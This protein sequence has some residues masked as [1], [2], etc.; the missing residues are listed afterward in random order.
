MSK[1]Q[2]VKLSD[3]S[4]S[5]LGKMLDQNKN[6]GEYQPYLANI[7]VRWGEFDLDH[8]GKMKFEKH[9]EERY[10]LQYGDLLVCEGGEPGR[11]AIWKNQIPNMKFQ[12]ALHRVRANLSVLDNRFLFYWFLLAGKTGELEQYF[13]GATIKHM[14]RQKLKEVKIFLPP[15]EVQRKIA[16]VL[17]AYD[18]LIENNRKQIKLLE[19]AAQRLYKE[20][21][22]DLRFPGHENTKIIDGIPEGWEKKPIS[23]IAE[24]LNG[25]AFKP[26][27][28]QKEGKPIIKIKEM[29]QG[30][31]D[32]TP[33]NNGANIPLKYLIRC[34]D[35]LFSWSATLSV[36]IWNQEDGW[37]NQ[38][39]FKVT[40]VKGFSRE[41]VLQAIANTLNEFQNLTTGA[42]MKHIQRGKLDEV[43]INV[44]TSLVMNRFAAYTEPIRNKILILSKQIEDIQETRNRL[45]PKLMTGELE[46]E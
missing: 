36:M 32:D 35:I 39:L 38:H 13:T 15:L 40:P 16:D 27:D 7:D 9:E 34:G 17:S 11:C 12:K 4:E 33:R 6:K 1:W 5:V 28:W 25:F 46:V 30:V 21:F 10:G 42:T 26:S 19:E 31:S 3:V 44:P 41:F 20:W 8:L 23:A 45:L 43:F 24:Y 2:R 14:P 18:D 22:I 37:L 29:N